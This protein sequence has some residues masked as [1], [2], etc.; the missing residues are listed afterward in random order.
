MPPLRQP[1]IVL[2]DVELNSFER[3]AER[4]TDRILI[5]PPIVARLRLS[6]P[7]KLGKVGRK[8]EAELLLRGVKLRLRVSD[9]PITHSRTVAA[10]C[11]VFT[12]SRHQQ[13]RTDYCAASHA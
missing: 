2:L 7:Q 10:E 1:E 3:P 12:C 5:H 4:L 6:F 9:S 8:P 13:P 11:S